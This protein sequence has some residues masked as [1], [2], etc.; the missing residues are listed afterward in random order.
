MNHTR[1]AKPI[2]ASTFADMVD[3]PGCTDKKRALLLEWRIEREAELLGQFFSK[4]ATPRA[5]SMHGIAPLRYIYRRPEVVFPKLT[6][7]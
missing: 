7:F 2:S 4:H 5:P 3:Q 1:N 6:S